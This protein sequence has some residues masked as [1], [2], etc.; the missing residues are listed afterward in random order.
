MTEL[1]PAEQ[2]ALDQSPD[3]PVRVAD[4][5]TQ[6]VEVL[7]RADDFNWVRGLLQDEPDAPVRQDPRT[8]VTYAVLPEDRYERFKAF[9]EEDPLTEAEKRALLRD[10]GR[11][12][13]WNDPV[14]RS[15]E[16]P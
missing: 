5:Q 11:R 7:L 14:W 13:G 4:P 1:T 8:G 15:A 2:K 6:R 10:A 3:I 12:A 9:F 16:Q